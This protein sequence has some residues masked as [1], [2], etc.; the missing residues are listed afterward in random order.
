MADSRPGS[1]THESHRKRSHNSDSHNK[2]TKTK[3]FV[4]KNEYKSDKYSGT[5]IQTTPEKNVLYIYRGVLSTEVNL[6]KKYYFGGT[7][8]EVCFIEGCAL[9]GVPLYRVLN[10]VSIRK[11][12]GSS[13]S[14]RQDQKLKTLSQLAKLV[15]SGKLDLPCSLIEYIDDHTSLIDQIFTILTLEDIEGMLPDILKV[16]YMYVCKSKV[17]LYTCV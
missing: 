12:E 4:F 13:S 11:R 3:R 7:N 9:R 15:Q 5:P 10:E 17:V 1:S 2:H 6:I 14:S 8:R 16:Y